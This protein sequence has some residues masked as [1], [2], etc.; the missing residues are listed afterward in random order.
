[1]PKRILLRSNR[2][3]ETIQE[4]QKRSN[5]L[6]VFK[7]KFFRNWFRFSVRDTMRMIIIFSNVELAIAIVDCLVIPTAHSCAHFTKLRD[8]GFARSKSSD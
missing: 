4:H 7:N 3:H 1:V 2:A 5:S 8:G 6:K